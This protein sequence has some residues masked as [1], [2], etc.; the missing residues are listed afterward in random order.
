MSESAAVIPPSLLAREVGFHPFFHR[1][2]QGAPVHPIHGHLLTFLT[3][4]SRHA[5]YPKPYSLRRFPFP[6]SSSCIED[7][8]S[9]KLRTMRLEGEFLDLVARGST[10]DLQSPM[11]SLRSS[12]VA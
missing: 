11:A 3:R 9:S 6:Y 12:L 10:K 8:Q 5:L 4:F 1:Y 7:C 2:A